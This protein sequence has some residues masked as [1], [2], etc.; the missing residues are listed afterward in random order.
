M[1]KKHA[2]CDHNY[3]YLQFI[4]WHPLRTRKT[5]PQKYIKIQQA[6]EQHNHLQEVANYDLKTRYKINTWSNY[7]NEVVPH[8][9][10]TFQNNEN[11]LNILPQKLFIPEQ[12]WHHDVKASAIQVFHV[13]KGQEEKTLEPLLSWIYSGFTIV[14]QFPHHKKAFTFLGFFVLYSRETNHKKKVSSVT[15]WGAKLLNCWALRHNLF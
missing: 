2:S 9:T 13:S 7:I 10:G 3:S 8:T 12:T 1:A 15:Y 6:H 5:T 4:L 14:P 11:M